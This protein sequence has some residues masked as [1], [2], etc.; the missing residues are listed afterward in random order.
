MN[1]FISFKEA[2]EML[3]CSST[4]IYKLINSGQIS[5][6][7]DGRKWLLDINSIGSFIE[8][9]GS[10]KSYHRDNYSINLRHKIKDAFKK[11]YTI[12]VCSNRFLRNQDFKIDWNYAIQ[13]ATDRFYKEKTIESAEFLSE[14]QRLYKRDDTD[15]Y[16]NLVEGE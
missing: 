5:G 9:G 4:S 2:K 7:R 6:Q 8:H 16:L 13:Q 3:H 10:I 15:A 12:P 11:D 14:V 1:N